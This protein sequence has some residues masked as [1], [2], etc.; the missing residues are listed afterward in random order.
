MGKKNLYLNS[1]IAG[2]ETHYV[3]Y[4]F[5]TDLAKWFVYD[6]E[7]AKSGSKIMSMEEKFN[8]F[9]RGDYYTPIYSARFNEE[10]FTFDFVNTADPNKTDAI[11]IYVEK[12]V[13][14]VFGKET[15][16]GYETLSKE[17]NLISAKKQTGGKIQVQ[18]DNIYHKY[19]KYKNKYIQLRNSLRY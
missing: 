18:N 3:V 9:P 19:L 6:G 1:I 4:S 14:P 15:N 16:K 11:F 7:R 13:E 5:C 2:N 17:S 12:I 8:S 10:T